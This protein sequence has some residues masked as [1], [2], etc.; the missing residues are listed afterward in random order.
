MIEKGQI[1]D[2]KTIT[3]PFWLILGFKKEMLRREVWYEKEDLYCDIQD[4]PL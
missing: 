1:D 4:V 2:C 3:Y